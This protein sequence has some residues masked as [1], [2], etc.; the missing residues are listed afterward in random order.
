[1]ISK[2]NQ[3]KWDKIL[4]KFNDYSNLDVKSITNNII[5]LKEIFKR[6]FKVKNFYRNKKLTSLENKTQKSID[7]AFDH[8]IKAGDILEKVILDVQKNHGFNPYK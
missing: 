6:A 3:S 7:E 1:M 5:E 4:L 2:N 8:I